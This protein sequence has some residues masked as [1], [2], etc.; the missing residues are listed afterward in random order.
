[1]LE[2]VDQGHDDF[3]NPVMWGIAAQQTFTRWLLRHALWT[4]G[5]DTPAGLLRRLP[6]FDLSEVIERVC[7]PVLAM[8]AEEDMFFAGLEHAKKV[9]TGLNSPKTLQVF[10]ADE[11][12]G[13][14]CHSGAMRLFHDRLFAWLTKT[15]GPGQPAGV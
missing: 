3:A 5:T 12:G 6:E 10:T 2:W 15:L 13:A 1:M 8:D 4:F 14:H 7:C 9:Y 11:G